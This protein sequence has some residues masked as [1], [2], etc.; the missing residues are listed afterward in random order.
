MTRIRRARPA[1]PGA[2]AVA[3]VLLTGALT[4][5]TAA[6]PAHT[7]TPTGAVSTADW[8]TARLYHTGRTDIELVMPS[9]AR[10]LHVDFSCTAGLYAVAPAV[11]GIDTRSGSC[12][13]AQAFDFD[14][15]TTAAGSRV[16]VDFSVPNDTRFVAALRFSLRPFTPDA[17]TKQ[18]CSALAQITEAFWNADQAVEHGDLTDAGW[19]EKTDPA[20]AKLT[21]LSDAAQRDGAAA[22]L[23]GPVIPQLASWL[24]GDGDHPGG[25]LHAPLGDFTAADALAGQ[26]CSANGTPMAIHSSYG[27]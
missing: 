7:A 26:I 18:Q 10:T 25:M 2:L 5:C 21:A 1:I 17:A 12:G 13:G 22:G 24:T 4:A 19:A 6:A 27:G 11:G 9:G 16:R 8:P 3:A 14:L 23:L 20:K 15:G